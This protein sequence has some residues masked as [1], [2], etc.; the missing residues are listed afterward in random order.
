MGGA[1]E[2]DAPKPEI[3]VADADAEAEADDD[4]DADVL[5]PPD[6]PMEPARGAESES[7]VMD[8]LPSSPIRAET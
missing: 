5:R 1:E 4:A 2:R 3:E 6:W 8:E 7:V